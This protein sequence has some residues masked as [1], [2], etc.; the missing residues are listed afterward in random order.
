MRRYSED[1]MKS[2]KIKTPYA[3]NPGW[4][5]VLP[6]VLAITGVTSLA[7][8]VAGVP[9][10]K[11][12]PAQKKS[13]TKNALGPDVFFAIDH[14]NVSELKSLLNQGA[15]P[16]FRNAL[17]FLPLYIAGASHQLDAMKALISANANV[18][19]ESPYGTALTLSSATGHTAGVNLLIS[20][21]ARVNYARM[22]GITPLMMAANAG[23]PSTIAELLKNKANPNLKNTSGATALSYAARNGHLE[24]GRLLLEAGTAVNTADALGE[25]PLMAAA[26]SGRADFVQMLIAKGANVNA[27]DKRGRTALLLATT[28]GDYPEVVKAL[29]EGGAQSTA[30]DG[31]GRTAGE[32]LALH[33]HRN[34]AATPGL[35]G[36]SGTRNDA[37]EAIDKSL[38]LLQ[39]SMKDFSQKTG[40]ISCHH[41]GLGRMATGL[42]MSRGYKID[43]SLQQG[44][45]G[46]VKGGMT[47]M[48][49]LH[50]Q[51]MKSPEAMKQVPLIEINEVSTAYSWFLAGMAA[52]NDAPTAGTAAAASVL[53]RQQRP[54]G[55]WTFS[56]PRI[57]MQSSTFTTTA[58][59][60]KSLLAYAPKADAAA[61]KEQIE[62]A[63]AWLL[64]APA[65]TS[66][67]LAFR[68]LGLKWAGATS[69]EMQTAIDDLLAQQLADGGWAQAPGMHTDGYAT[70]QA[71]Y[72][73]R[74]AGVP[75]T[76]PVVQKGVQYLLRTQDDDGSWFVTKRAI[77]ANNYFDAS[78][79][80]GESQYSS[81][82]GTNW[83]VMALLECL[84]RK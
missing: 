58:L 68:L 17:G 39:A 1:K 63:K 81:Y 61:T 28:Y 33:G 76:H 47:M 23:A 65:K 12:A 56:M 45:S 52:Q 69:E 4:R 55:N 32:L 29:L 38:A 2:S 46:R 60:I 10:K 3:S 74:V 67:D 24:A 75:T 73:L 79:P 42:A 21:G 82:N 6:T 18:D 20:K 43:K 15:D 16:N 77:P 19:A 71:V 51:A 30:K 53:A 80:H 9:Q 59:A 40:C 72:A 49:P 36:K 22:D 37:A 13:T 57:P 34:S 8:G 11:S 35:S 66:D 48:L 78:F 27:K 54:E 7:I 62:K 25:T 14:R 64:K 83:A 31:K 84:P 5:A 50:V 70:G 44:Q 41:E 26:K